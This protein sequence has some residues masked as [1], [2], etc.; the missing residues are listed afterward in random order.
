MQ[1][2]YD[3]PQIEI[4]T[5]RTEPVTADGGVTLSNEGYFPGNW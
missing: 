2:H 3:Q 1:R 4:Q 5:V